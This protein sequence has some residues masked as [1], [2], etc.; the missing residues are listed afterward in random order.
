M[1]RADGVAAAM[2]MEVVVSRVWL[3]WTCAELSCWL[4]QRI[5]TSMQ[6]LLSALLDEQ[7]SAGLSCCARSSVALLAWVAAPACCMAWAGQRSLASMRLCRLCMIAAGAAVPA[8]TRY[9]YW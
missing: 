6:M 9:V 2:D 1:Q 8:L 3:G 5:A 7:P 4:M